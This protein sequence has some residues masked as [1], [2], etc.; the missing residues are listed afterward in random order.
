MNCIV[1]IGDV[2]LND[3]VRKENHVY[4]FQRGITKEEL[5]FEISQFE[6]F[7]EHGIVYREEIRGFE[8]IW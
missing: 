4:Y 8:Y 7:Y 6:L 1:T 3:E 5:D 2:I